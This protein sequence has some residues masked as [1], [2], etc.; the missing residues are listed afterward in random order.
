M[1]RR[2]VIPDTIETCTVFVPSLENPTARRI[3]ILFFR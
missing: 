3:E 1:G 2:I